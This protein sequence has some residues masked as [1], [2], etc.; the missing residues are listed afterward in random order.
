MNA[1]DPEDAIIL[2]DDELKVTIVADTKITN[3]ATFKVLKEDHTL[4][5]L[6]RMQLL[7]DPIVRFAGYKM[8]HPLEN[9]LEV[10]VQT[11][12][13]G[14]KSKPVDVVNEALDE[15]NNEI[16]N[17]QQQFDDLIAKRNKESEALDEETM[18]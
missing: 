8:P 17:I 13:V 5:N 3:A 18:R 1:P 2:Q 6:L 11:S 7:R 15:L 14:E 12:G 10:K 16:K 9:V 4:G